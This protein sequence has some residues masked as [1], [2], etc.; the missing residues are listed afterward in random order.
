MHAN[1]SLILGTS[2]PSGP[3]PAAILFHSRMKLRVL[4]RTGGPR[5][6]GSS[7]GGAPGGLAA[8][9]GGAAWSQDR[10]QGARWLGMSSGGPGHHP[11]PLIP[12]SLMGKKPWTFMAL[13]K[14]GSR[15]CASAQ[16]GSKVSLVK[17]P[18]EANS[19]S[20]RCGGRFQVWRR[21]GGAREG[22]ACVGGRLRS[23]ARGCA[24]LVSQLRL[25]ICSPLH[26]PGSCRWLQT[27]LVPRTLGKSSWRASSSAA[28]C[29]PARG[30]AQP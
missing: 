27:P 7:G 4:S 30:R 8:A 18:L 1:Q 3:A 26:R 17:M 21:G 23:V 5:G 22:C 12:R 20:R 15:P 19:A 29:R 9:A 28:T 6:G 11:P 13:K 10:D 14:R 24:Q 16:S 25:G 2:V